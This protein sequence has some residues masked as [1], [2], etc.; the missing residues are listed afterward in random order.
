MAQKEG[1]QIY[2]HDVIYRFLDDIKAIM[3][4]FLP[5]ELKEN[6]VGEGS[7]LEVSPRHVR[8][9]PAIRPVEPYLSRVA[10][11]WFTYF[12]P[13]GHKWYCTMYIALNGLELAW[14]A[15]LFVNENCSPVHIGK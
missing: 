7:T 4:E 8:G 15:M 12:H 14:H 2:N 6:V 3:S 1:V 11:S 13:T 5:V 10:G 9:R